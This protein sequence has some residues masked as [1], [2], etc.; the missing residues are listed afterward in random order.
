MNNQTTLYFLARAGNGIFA[1]A[2]LVVFTRILNPEEYGLYALCV[3]TAT[4]ISAVMFQWLTVSTA[5]FYPLH[6]DAPEKIMGVITRAFWGISVAG[7]LIALGLI[8]F[9]KVANTEPQVIG[10]I[11]LITIVLGRYT[12]ALQIA[13]SQGSA[14]AYC[15]IS[16]SKCGSALLA[17]WYLIN[18]GYGELGALAGLFF[19]YLIA[20]FIYEPKQKAAASLAGPD[21]GLAKEMFGY[22]M[23]L[24]L[25]F[26]ALVLVDFIDRFL[27]GSILGVLYVGPYAAAYDLV[28]LL[29]GPF[30]NIFL[31]V[32]FPK[33]VQM[34]DNARRDA[35]DD[36]LKKL[37]AR[38]VTFGMP[39]AVGIGAISTEISEIIFGTQYQQESAMIMPWIAAA[40]FLATIKSYYYDLVFQ[41][42]RVPRYQV[43][44]AV[45]MVLVNIIL[46]FILLP[47]YGVVASA[48][49]TLASFAAGTLASALVGKY[50]FN[51]QSLINVFI[52]CIVACLVMLMVFELTPSFWGL[53]SIVFKSVVGAIA[54][55]ATAYL[56][57]I[58]EMR[59]DIKDGLTK[60]GWVHGK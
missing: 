8:P 44:I 58:G 40:I 41:L 28:Q 5:R 24:T 55:A 48:W 57:D 32:A 39:L 22:G 25:N 10:V 12:L 60:A 16:W 23:P 54:Y 45:I 19:G 2:T 34:F 49:A 50:M 1:G 4:I 36:H 42:N 51:V 7:A 17:G 37:G 21:A 47:I 20:I 9:A 53:G 18:L 27:I 13:N 30:M 56:L 31:L 33:I 14:L 26:L 6:L 43:Y 35:A 11:F 52:K 3:A 59:L 29:I 15:K 46:N 38:L